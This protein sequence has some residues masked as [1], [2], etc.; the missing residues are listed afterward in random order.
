MENRVNI[1]IDINTPRDSNDPTCKAEPN[2]R[3]LSGHSDIKVERS[4]T[5]SS[6]KIK[7][8]RENENIKQS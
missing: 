7:A 1:T 4:S 8:Y 2:K 3:S 5:V 6:S